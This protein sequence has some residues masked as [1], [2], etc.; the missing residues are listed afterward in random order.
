MVVQIAA[1][2]SEDSAKS[3]RQLHYSEVPVAILAQLLRVFRS[4][5]RRSLTHCLFPLAPRDYQLRVGGVE[6]SGPGMS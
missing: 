6:L 1:N 4:V 3:P 2:T 5:V